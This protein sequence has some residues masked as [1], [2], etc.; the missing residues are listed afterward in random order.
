MLLHDESMVLTIPLIIMTP[1]GNISGSGL[2]TLFKSSG[3]S[4]ELHIV[5]MATIPPWTTLLVQFD[6]PELTVA[7]RISGTIS[8][9]FR[10]TSEHNTAYTHIILSDCTG[11]A[12]GFNLLRSGVCSES[13]KSWGDMKRH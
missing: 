7:P 4:S 13:L 5:S 2:A 11:D 6:L 12:A 9:A 3:A 1:E 8:A 10:Q